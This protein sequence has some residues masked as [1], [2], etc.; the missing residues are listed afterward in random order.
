MNK[1][2]II[3]KDKCSYNIMYKYSELSEN[4]T[5]LIKKD[6]KKK[7]GIYF[8]PP[9]T[10]YK[11]LEYIDPYISNVKNVL[12]PS[13][14]S[15][16]YILALHKKY[17]KLDITGIEYNKDI[18]NS[19]KNLSNKKINLI[20][21]N[22]LEYESVKKYDL[23]IGNPPYFVMKKKDVN[24]NYYKYFDGR[25]NIFI[26]FI[27]KSI[28][29]LSDNGILSFILPKSFINC[30]YYDKT[31]KFIIKNFTIIKI[32]ECNEKYIDTEQET[33]IFIIQK[34]KSSNTDNFI[35]NIKDYTI[36]GT[37]DNIEKIKNLYENSK[38]LYELGFE[39]SVGNVVWNQCKNILTDDTTKTRLIYS[40]DIKNNKLTFKKYNNK[41]KKNY[42]NK[43][44]KKEPVLLI[45]RGYGV[46]NYNFE[47]CFIDGSFEYL[48]EN[49]LICISYTKS[50]INNDIY[51]KIIKSLENSK[52]IEFIKLYFGNNAI[53]T[54]ELNHIFP[55]YDI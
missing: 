30:L 47:Y 12:E 50:L 27:L 19:I 36:F 31:R 46:G 16:E 53:N 32:I 28:E 22:Y 42:I 45:N 17:K 34:K 52:T 5:K 10:I 37:E 18:Y 40:T 8:T 9:E 44:G 14:G 39:V 49:H 2:L 21:K 3:N 1:K 20:N 4:L 11:N 24:K 26:L 41:D 51:K 48:I 6:V 25:P 29:I 33:I 55:I 43:T 23:I 38:T 54:T 35:I 7:N 15:C 13:C